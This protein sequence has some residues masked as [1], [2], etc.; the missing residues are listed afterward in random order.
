M[1]NIE[2]ENLIFPKSFYLYSTH[3]VIYLI[4][5]MDHKVLIDSYM[6]SKY[7]GNLYWFFHHIYM[8]L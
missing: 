6:N 5:Q 1:V 7:M 3:T 2:P 4:H 8:L